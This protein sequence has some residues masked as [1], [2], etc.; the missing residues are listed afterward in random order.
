M[1]LRTTV[2][3]A[4]VLIGCALAFGWGVHLW[5]PTDWRPD[6]LQNVVARVHCEDAIPWRVHAQA[7]LLLAVVAWAK[8]GPKKERRE[9]AARGGA[10]ACNGRE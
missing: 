4:V 1:G 10:R 5:L 9:S 6:G 2:V 7:A 3:Y 8:W